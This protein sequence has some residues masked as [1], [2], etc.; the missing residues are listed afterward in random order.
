MLLGDCAPVAA[1]RE[2]RTAFSQSRG[3]ARRSGDAE[4]SIR[5][6]SGIAWRDSEHGVGHRLTDR[7][8]RD[9]RQSVLGARQQRAATWRGAIHVGQDRDVGGLKVS[10]QLGGR[11]EARPHDARTEL[12][13][14]LFETRRRL[15]IGRIAGADATAQHQQARIG[16]R[17]GNQIERV[18]QCVESFARV[19]QSKVDQHQVTGGESELGSN[20]AFPTPGTTATFEPIGT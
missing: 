15:A 12:R 11:L 10:G 19:E 1:C 20:R 3:F 18:Q 9:N 6:R 2:R 13:Q 14:S 5:Q 8:R 16:S 7:L 17:G 4:N